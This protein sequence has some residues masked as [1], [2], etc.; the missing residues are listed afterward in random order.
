LAWDG[1][2]DWQERKSLSGKRLDAYII[3]YSVDA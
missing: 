1:K 3:A 2:S